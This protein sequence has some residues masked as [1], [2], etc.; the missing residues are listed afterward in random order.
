M[1]WI[2]PI[3]PVT[4]ELV[5]QSVVVFVSARGRVFRRPATR[6]TYGRA[7]YRT[8]RTAMLAWLS[9]KTKVPPFT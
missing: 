7:D 2:E 6:S 5:S 9:V 4:K 1:D 3:V 8:E